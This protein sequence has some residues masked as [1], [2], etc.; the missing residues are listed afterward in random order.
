MEKLK[1]CPFCGSEAFIYFVGGNSKFNKYKVSCKNGCV[2]MP[3]RFDMNF[4]SQLEALKAWNKRHDPNIEAG[5]NF[6]MDTSFGG[7]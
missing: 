7:G 1:K 6:I 4:T 5:V 2:T 3:P